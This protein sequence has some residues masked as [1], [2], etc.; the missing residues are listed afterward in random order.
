MTIPHIDPIQIVETL[1]YIGI[2]SIVLA[3]SGIFIGFFLPGD[4]LLM[5][6]GLFATQGTLSIVTLLI[7]VPIAAILGDSIGYSFG[8]FIGPRL[9]TK[10]DSWLFNKKHIERSRKFYEKHGPRAVLIARFIPIVRTFV[11]IIAGVGEMKYSKFLMYNIVGGFLWADIFLLA[12]YFLGQMIPNLE[13][14]IL[15]IVAV[16]IL[17]SILPIGWE[18]YKERKESKAQ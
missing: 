13:V 12:G 10:E 2:F 11:P 5:T 3:E 7:I 16:I 17:L 6:A 14:Y 9:F 1:G 4:S 15:P 18:W 8:K